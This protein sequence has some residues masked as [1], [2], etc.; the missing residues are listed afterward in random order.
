MHADFLQYI[1][2]TAKTGETLYARID[3]ARAHIFDAETTEA[4]SE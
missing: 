2:F 1:P 4:L 3:Q